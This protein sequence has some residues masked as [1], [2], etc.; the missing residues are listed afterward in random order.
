MG[1]QI[2]YWMEF[3]SFLPVAQKALDLGCN[4]IKEN[5]NEGTVTVGSDLSIIKK[6]ENYC[7]IK[8]YFHFP[9][10]GDIEIHK[11]NGKEWLENSF[12]ASGNAIIEAGFSYVT[13][14]P[15]GSDGKPQ[16]KEIQRARLY[17]ISGYY[18]KNENY[19][20]RPESLTKVY[21]SLERFVKKVA[22]YT[23]LTE[24]RTSFKA[25]NYG[26]QYEFKH[27]EYVTEY[28]LNLMQNEGYKLV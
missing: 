2:N 6:P 21:N 22:P 18:D 24:I 15:S 3:D 14:V 1:R 4:I 20:P 28:C 11:V 23:E 8:Y 16:I 26:E 10:A 13:N 25:E 7:P 27:K 9:Q 5:L 19:V 17:C 12:S